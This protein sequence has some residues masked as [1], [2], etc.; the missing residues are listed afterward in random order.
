MN[1]GKV[2]KTQWYYAFWAISTVTVLAGQIYVGLGYRLMSK[3]IL[4]AIEQITQTTTKSSRLYNQKES[5]QVN[6]KIPQGL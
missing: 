2:N 6:Q 5:T 4:T 3:S 1:H